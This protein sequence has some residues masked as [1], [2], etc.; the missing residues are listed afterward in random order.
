MMAF[1]A[2]WNENF[3]FFVRSYLIS[4]LRSQVKS[5]L[6]VRSIAS[7]ELPARSR[8]FMWLKVR[9]MFVLN[10]HDCGR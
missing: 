9:C 7:A 1:I 10:D 3:M 6:K 8:I 4:T 2:L 5:L